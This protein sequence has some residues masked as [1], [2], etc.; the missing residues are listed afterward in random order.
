MFLCRGL[1]F[2]GVP[3]FLPGILRTLEQQAAEPLAVLPPVRGP[4]P[5]ESGQKML[6]FFL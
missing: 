3:V 2:Q 5:A 1:S 4:R 6:N